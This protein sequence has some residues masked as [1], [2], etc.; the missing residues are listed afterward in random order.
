MIVKRYLPTCP[1]DIISEASA[2][3]PAYVAAY[4]ASN[5]WGYQFTPSS[6]KEVCYTF[7]PFDDMKIGTEITFKIAYV[8]ET[9]ESDV[10]IRWRHYKDVCPIGGGTRS[11]T[12]FFET[13]DAATITAGRLNVVAF[14]TLTTITDMDVLFCCSF[15]RVGDDGADNYTGSAN[16]WSIWIEYV[17]ELSQP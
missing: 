3:R 10:R 7:K 5:V 1:W 13:P 15:Q 11:T 14:S 2:K 12:S 9:T 6:I 16:V 4:G 17:S 8:G